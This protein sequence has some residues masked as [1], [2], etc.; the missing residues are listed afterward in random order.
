MDNAECKGIGTCIWNMFKMNI[1][2]VV[3]LMVLDVGGEIPRRLAVGELMC[4]IIERQI[5]IEV[6]ETMVL[7]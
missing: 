3:L 6:A 7:K 5:G 1:T 2:V 4:D